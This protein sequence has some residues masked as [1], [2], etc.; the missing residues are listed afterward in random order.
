MME[1]VRFLMQAFRNGGIECFWRGK[2]GKKC[3]CPRFLQI[4]ANKCFVTFGQKIKTFLWFFSNKDAGQVVSS[5]VWF[6]STSKV[7]TYET[8]ED[9]SMSY[10]VHWDSFSKN[11]ATNLTSHGALCGPN[12]TRCNAPRSLRRVRR[13]WRTCGSR[14]WRVQ[15]MACGSLSGMRSDEKMKKR[16]C[17]RSLDFFLEKMQMKLMFFFYLL[18]TASLC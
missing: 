3:F 1:R 17:T 12:P 16:L 13:C 11:K 14:R 8:N 6:L 10:L 5:D 9:W 2:K 15:W 4:L 7:K 18:L